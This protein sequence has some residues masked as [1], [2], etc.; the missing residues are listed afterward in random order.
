M[1]A[2][3]T[4]KDIMPD[5]HLQPK[6]AFSYDA[7]RD[8]WNG[9]NPDDHQAVIEE[10]RKIETAKQQLKAEKLQSELLSG[11]LSES[12]IKVSVR[13]RERVCVCVCVC[14]C[15]R[16]RVQVV[17]SLLLWLIL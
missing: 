9:Y 4:G 5:E 12:S 15:A 17:N 8:R 2:K 10:Y 11:K 6:L 16:F 13:E 14:V 3:F 7:K 1:G